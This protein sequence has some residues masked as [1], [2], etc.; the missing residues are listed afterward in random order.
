MKKILSVMLVLCISIVLLFA[1]GTSEKAEAAAKTAG[2]VPD[3]TVTGSI[4]IYTSIYEDIV[5]MMDDALA[6]KFPNCNIEFFQ[7]GTGNIQTKVAGEMSTGKLGCDMMLVA[8]PAY[9][10]ELDEEG[11]LH[12]YLSPNR[13][14]LRFDYDKDGAWYPVR[15]CNMVLAYNPE[16]YKPSDL[17]TSYKDFAADSALK[18]YI[19]M[20]NPL[21][22]GTT[23]AAA[24]ALSEKYGFG[25]FDQLG[26]QQVMVESGSTALAKLETGE[27]KELM[28]LE[29]SVLKKREEEGS[30][31]SVIYPDDGVI[32]IPSTVMTVE[33]DKSANNNVAS[34]EKVTDWL[35]SEEGQRFIVKGWMHSVLKGWN[36]GDKIPY[37]S[38][39]TD[40]L[41]KKDM[42]LDWVR[43]YKQR[44]EIREAFEKSVSLSK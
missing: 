13:T 12:K 39:S 14:N 33:G 2:I 8:E 7:G 9:S 27:C 42:G 3:E 31:I 10:L 34:C 5:T 16:M 15:V 32:L 23:M 29:E 38:I 11:F 28:I 40:D 24:A 22:S 35:L 26:E 36:S 21:T 17:A 44:T 18:G 20:G 41:I 1:G 43:C 25:Y 19:S 4:M 37:D 30:S 6:E